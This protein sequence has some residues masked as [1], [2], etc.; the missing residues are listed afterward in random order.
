LSIY[1]LITFKDSNRYD[2]E[3]T[4][5]ITVYDSD[6]EAPTNKKSIIDPSANGSLEKDE[7]G[8]NP[9]TKLDAIESGSNSVERKQEEERQQ[10]AVL[11]QVFRRALI[12]SSA[13]TIIVAI[14]GSS[15]RATLNCYKQSCLIIDI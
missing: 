11:K 15:S 2:F 8:V 3:A 9:D 1:T 6:S 12:Y 14:V 10:R 7:D 4:R 13:L 5:A